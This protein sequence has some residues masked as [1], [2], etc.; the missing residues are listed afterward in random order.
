VDSVSLL[1]DTDAVHAPYRMQRKSPDPT[2]DVVNENV[3]GMSPA[4]DR[5]LRR[6]GEGF[7]LFDGGGEL[8][9]LMRATDWSQTPLGPPEKWPQSLRTCVRIVLTSRQAMFVW[10]GDALVNLYNDAYR[11]ILGGK[12]PAA[13]GQPAAVVWREIWDQV[14]PRAET[15]MRRNEGTYDEALLLIME[16]HGYR[17]ETYYTFSYSPVPNDQGGAGGILCANTD[18]TTR[19]IGERQL[20]LLNELATRIGPARSA[21]EACLLAGAGLESDPH[22][23]PFALIY[24]LDA[25]GSRVHLLGHAGVAGG[26]PAAPA[27]MALDGAP[28]WP[29]AGLL[30]GDGGPR[31]VELGPEFGVLPGGAWPYPPTQAAMLPLPR[32]GQTGRAGVLVAG[33]SPCRRYDDDYQR[34]LGL[35]AGQIA[36]G[37]A[38]ADAYEEE[39]RRAEALAE[40]DRAKTLFFSN[41][42]HEFRTPLTLMLGPLED[43]L[44]ADGPEALAAAQRQQLLVAHRNSLRLLR[45][46]NTLLDFSRIEAGRVQATFRP[47]DLAALTTDLASGFRSAIERA[48]LTL[49]IDCPKLPAPVFVDRDMWEKIVLNLMSNAFKF[50]FEGGIAVT[51]CADGADAVLTVQDSGVGIPSDELPRVFERFH[52]IEGQRSRSFEG[53]GIGL[54]LVHELVRLHGGRIAARSEPARGT[55]FTVAI[56]FGTAH[57]PPDKVDTVPDVGGSA[58]LEAYVEEAMRWLPEGDAGGIEFPTPAASAGDAGTVAQPGACVLLADDNADMRDYVRRLLGTRYAVTAVADGAAA[59]AAIR[60]RR[61]DLVLSD[62]MMPGLDGFGLLRAIRADPALRELPVILLSARAGEEARAEGLDAGADDYLTKP[63]SA[64]ELFA[65][66]GANLAMARVRREAAEAL[67]AR[68]AELEA[69]LETVPVAV[70]FTHDADASRIEGNRTAARMLR[71]R[72]GDNPSVTG[73]DVDRPNHFRMLRGGTD[74]PATQLPMQRAARGEA[75]EPEELEIR[76]ND[77]TSTSVLIT[78]APVRDDAGRVTG[79]IC[80]ATDITAQ[81]HA[82]T[83]L[84]RL[85]ETLEARVAER[86]A[87]RDRVWHNSQ[88]L[89]AVADRDGIFRAVNPAWTT[90]L[91]HHPSEV[92]GRSFR[93]FVWPEDA[94]MSER[95]HGLA[96]AKNSLTNFENRFRH[97]DGTPRWISWHSSTENDLIFGSGRDITA[98]KAAAAELAMAQEQLRQAQKM[99]AIGQLTGGI[100]HD[101]NNL[102]TGI[103]GSLE[104]LRVR[105]AQGRLSE[106][107]RFVNAAMTSV[108]R[109]AALTHR[110]LAF[111]RRQALDPKPTGVNRLVSGMEELIRRTVGP[112]VQV[113]TVLAAGLWPTLCDANQLESALLNLCIN[114]RDAMPDGGR[115]TIETA[116]VHLD[117]A[118]AARERDVRAGQYVSLSVTD[119]G[120][121]MPPDVIARAFE[122]FFTTKPIGQGTGLG[123]SMLY[124][125]VKQSEGHVRIYS[126]LDQGTTVRLYLPRLRNGDAGGD[127]GA[128][129]PAVSSGPAAA[130]GETVLVVEDEDVVRALIVEVLADL[131]YAALEAA[132]G[133]EGLRI[134]RS[135]A[136]IDLLVTDVGLPGMNGRQLADAARERRPELKVLFITG[137]A[138]NAAI[139]SAVLGPGME[140]IV[141]PFAIDALATRIRTMIAQPGRGA[142][143]P[144]P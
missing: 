75:V 115:L 19:I 119:T 120:T 45:L 126:E 39:R 140:I 125:F 34:F 109:A 81:K 135:D 99:E 63:F 86:T 17:E 96:T 31:V 82:Q 53:S 42:S 35:V 67:R 8:G 112:A 49:G 29:L 18:D 139:G 5:G 142:G 10:W 108:N 47:T 113:E 20:T 77:G 79:A 141:K 61:P 138:H 51:L 118:Y 100:A 83:A 33:L 60:L 59:L 4:P 14:G 15:A 136:R 144:G 40:L 84:R 16:R 12:H 37:M 26:H 117:E 3:T 123:L 88:D 58:R 72:D 32:H 11:A 130:P 133:S 93:D 50:T 54:A 101:F 38:N 105:A 56:P 92:E 122:P 121:G 127:E 13:L 111:A 41:V 48:G 80:A 52:R 2:H 46:V 44:K 69:L 57:L 68:T 128:T 76:F 21:E 55:V 102:L 1:P 78:A 94:E 9:A 66:V 85:N 143:R 74:I 110:L 43:V 36:A 116:N 65:R 24:L 89:L 87:E 27:C 114:A 104:L 62:V 137:Y 91:G 124:G 70:W 7:A 25:D 73:P 132:D 106:L 131:G 6:D 98:E 103:S 129:V 90:I 107:D 95:G 97:K 134:V 30:R 23:L 64:R 22:D 71:L 28:R